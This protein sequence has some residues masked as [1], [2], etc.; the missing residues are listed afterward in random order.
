MA[1]LDVRENVAHLDAVRVVRVAARHVNL[2]E[3]LFGLVQAARRVHVVPPGVIGV[4]RA[5]IA[6]IRRASQGVHVEALLGHHAIGVVE[7]GRIAD[8][9][10]KVPLCCCAC[11]WRGVREGGLR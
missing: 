2:V 1:A 3:V 11:A 5:G 10:L 9:K 7:I 6:I 4:D 8:R